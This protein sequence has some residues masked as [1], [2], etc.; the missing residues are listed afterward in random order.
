MKKRLLTLLA[1]AGLFTAPLA[2][3]DGV[4]HACPPEDMGTHHFYAGVLFGYG[5]THWGDNGTLRTDSS[6]FVPKGYV[7]FSWNKYLA[8]Q[9]GF[10]YFT[11]SIVR[12]PGL[13]RGEFRNYA[14]DAVARLTVPFLTFEG[15][16]A[17]GVLGVA[18]THAQAAIRLLN[19][20][21]TFGNFN[22]THFGVTYGAGL[23]YKMF[24]NVNLILQWQRYPGQG[25]V[26]NDF[27]P[28]MDSVSLGAEFH[29][30]EAF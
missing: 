13:F 25:R 2:L 24:S 19:V 5:D 28:Y 6:A 12:G 10:T 3:A 14:V 30:P 21:T 4:S 17:F 20:P 7:G 8:A 18:Y 15:V 9:A 22:R 1:L 11:D 29:M 26:G 23:S 27:Q 16:H